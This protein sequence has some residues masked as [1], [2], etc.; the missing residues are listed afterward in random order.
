MATAALKQ[1]TDHG[2][3]NLR[4]KKLV[5]PILAPNAASMQVAAKCGYHLEGILKAEVVKA[6]QFYDIH[7][8]AIAVGQESPIAVANRTGA[9]SPHP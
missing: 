2:F 3:V 5:A 7:H 8:F 6:G 9:S 4:P 1:M